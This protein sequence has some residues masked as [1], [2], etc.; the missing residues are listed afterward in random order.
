M[1]NLKHLLFP[2]AFAAVVTF[3]S[4]SAK[5]R[6]SADVYASIKARPSTI[7]WCLPEAGDDPAH[8]ISG[9]CGVYRECLSG[10]TLD[11]S[12]DRTPFPS[13]GVDKIEPLR[14][15]HQA[16]FNGARVNPQIKGS[17]ATQRWLQHSVYPGT[18]AKS[19]PVPSGM[20][21]PR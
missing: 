9:I 6:A 2:F 8:I 20:G 10:A 12:V 3:C 18:E 1:R 17:S 5:A 14:K 7:R 15:C 21:D 11:E 16:F 13:L 4:L 19:F